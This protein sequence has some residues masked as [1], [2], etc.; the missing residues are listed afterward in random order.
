VVCKIKISLYTLLV[1]YAYQTH[2]QDGGMHAAF[3]KKIDLFRKLSKIRNNC[4]GSL[5]IILNVLSN[6]TNLIYIADVLQVAL[7]SV[8][9][10]T[11]YNFARQLTRGK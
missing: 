9:Y 7:R 11:L 1:T 5:Y 4:K 2:I 3:D 10:L 6:K 8:M